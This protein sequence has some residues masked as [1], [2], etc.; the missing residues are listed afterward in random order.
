MQVLGTS[1]N[2]SSAN[3][4]AKNMI[5]KLN[6]AIT[7]HEI[8]DEVAAK[9]AK[10]RAAATGGEGGPHASAAGEADEG[11][12]PA[13][14]RIPA[15]GDA[16]REAREEGASGDAAAAAALEDTE[17]IEEQRMQQEA[18]GAAAEAG[19]EGAQGGEGGEG[20]GGAEGAGEGAGAE[21]GSRAVSPEASGEAGVEGRQEQ[22]QQ[23]QRPGSR[24]LAAAAEDSSLTSEVNEEDEKYIPRDVTDM[25]GGEK[26][27]D[28]MDKPFPSA[29]MLKRRNSD[30]G[31]AR[32]KAE[33]VKGRM[34][35]VG[36]TRWGKGRRVCGVPVRRSC[37]A[38]AR[39]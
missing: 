27:Y 35:Q 14:V 28:N 6:D 4:I 20:A 37:L 18:E 22:Q 25:P 26:V 17:A 33:A 2:P 10:I 16:G 38:C 7:L 12:Q 3:A 39:G 30:G 23:Q 32:R 8:N 19:G 5:N 34:Q 21:E 15:T 36:R 29:M 13:A 9:T 31:R 11:A 1:F 24:N